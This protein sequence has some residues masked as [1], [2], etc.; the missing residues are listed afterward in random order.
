[1]C[2]HLFLKM[3]VEKNR[4]YILSNIPRRLTLSVRVVLFCAG[5]LLGATLSVPAW[6]EDCRSEYN[7]RIDHIEHN[8]AKERDEARR[9]HDLL[10]R[11]YREH[12]G[13]PALKEELRKDLERAKEE[14]ARIERVMV[15]KREEARRQLHECEERQR[16]RH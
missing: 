15:E 3:I 16:R 2:I 10:E 12:R 14:L 7:R 6:A 1:M 8:L 13:G 9:D 11:V 5:C 4:T